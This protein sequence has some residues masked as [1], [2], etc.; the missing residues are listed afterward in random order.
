[1]VGPNPLGHASSYVW[2]LKVLL[3]HFVY[4]NFIWM[5]YAKDITVF[6][7][8]CMIY[9]WLLQWRNLEKEEKEKYEEKAKRIAEE[10]QAKQEAAEKAFNESLNRSQS[11][12]SDQ[13]HAQSGTA[14]PT[15]PGSQGKGLYMVSLKANQGFVLAFEFRQ[16]S[17]CKREGQLAASSSCNRDVD[18]P[19]GGLRGMVMLFRVLKIY[20]FVKPLLTWSSSVVMNFNC[21]V[22]HFIFQHRAF[23]VQLNF[24]LHNIFFFWFLGNKFFP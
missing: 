23:L 5:K 8:H 20:I 21:T 18:M 13:V 16:C 1:M 24:H 19:K 10:Q 3:N 17:C 11:P 4:I 9:W 12:W 7:S 14:R 15:T 2:I 22:V 6:I